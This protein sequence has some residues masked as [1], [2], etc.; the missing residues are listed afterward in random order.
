M[1]EPT[2]MTDETI[3]DAIGRMRGRALYIEG[4]EPPTDFR[5]NVRLDD[6]RTLLATLDAP[7]GDER[8]GY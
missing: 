8:E 2:S 6:L 7:V 5:V 4:W 3:R 1:T